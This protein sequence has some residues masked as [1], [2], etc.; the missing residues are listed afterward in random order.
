MILSSFGDS[1]FNTFETSR[2]RKQKCLK[3]G[4]RGNPTHPEERGVG[5]LKQAKQAARSSDN[6]TMPQ[7]RPGVPI[8]TVAYRRLGGV[9][10]PLG[11]PPRNRE[12]VSCRACVRA[13]PMLGGNASQTSSA[14]F[15]FSLLYRW[16]F[17][18]PSVSSSESQ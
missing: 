6:E 3:T 4:L 15:P 16:P 7:T 17:P 10:S 12:I 5:P 13:E 8:G 2:C 11:R 9:S 18:F 14:P 1:I